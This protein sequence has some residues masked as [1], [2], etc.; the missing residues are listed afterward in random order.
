MHSRF[1]GI[2]GPPHLR[3]GLAMH[4]KV[5]V[6]I[7]KNPLKALHQNGAL[8]IKMLVG[9]SLFFIHPGIRKTPPAPVAMFVIC[10]LE[11]AIKALIDIITKH[12]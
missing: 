11:K 10:Q 8:G 12:G 6:E 3:P 7:Q 5:D 4:N 1:K 9:E 2:S